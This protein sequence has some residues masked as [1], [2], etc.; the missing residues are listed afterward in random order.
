MHVLYV[1]PDGLINVV[2]LFASGCPLMDVHV[3]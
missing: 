2:H 3:H 1:T